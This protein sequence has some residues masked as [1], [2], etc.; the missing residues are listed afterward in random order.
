M[1]QMGIKHKI[2]WFFLQLA[3]FCWVSV[4]HVQVLFGGVKCSGLG[5]RSLLTNKI[6]ASH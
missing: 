3:A 4:L 5:K 6:S 2:T 1:G